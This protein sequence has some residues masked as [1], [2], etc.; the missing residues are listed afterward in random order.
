MPSTAVRAGMSVKFGSSV[1]NNTAFRSPIGNRSSAYLRELSS[2]RREIADLQN[3]VAELETLKAE[4]VEMKLMMASF[5]SM[6][7]TAMR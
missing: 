1:P 4:F 6:Q 7:T 3:Q 2:A 5:T